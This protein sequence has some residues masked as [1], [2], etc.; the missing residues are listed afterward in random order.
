MPQSSA[1][2]GS[3]TTTNRGDST[4]FL[5]AAYYD[6]IDTLP[7]AQNVSTNFTRLV[8]GEARLV[9]TDVKRSIGAVDDEKGVAWQLVYTGNRVNGEIVPQ[10]RGG[11][12]LG[13]ALPI[14]NSS[15]WLRS[16]AGV[17]NGDR[18][19]TVAN[20][21]FGSFGN[22]YV[23]DKSVKR[24]RQYDKFPGFGID[25]ISALSFVR[26]MGEWNLPPVVFE[27]VGTPSLYVNWMR[28]S[29]FI[30]GLWADPGNSSLRKDYMSLG[31]QV[32][33]R[34]SVLHWYEM[35]LSAGYAVGY[36][37][38]QRA[39]SEWMISLKIM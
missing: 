26:E 1:T 8:T 24:Y 22:N 23:D 25:E 30:A 10:F 27:S 31:A 32:D 38:G 21:Y 14:G 29:I 11:L 39:G 35:T 37:G 6:Q 18:N 28:P 7:T 2:T 3:Y 12:D 34:L 15:V 4:C 13:L 36:Q 20:F 19:N 9:Y 33:L 16:A 17:A 5:D